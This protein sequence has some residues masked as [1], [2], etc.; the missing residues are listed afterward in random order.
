MLGGPALHGGDGFTKVMYRWS[1]VA[2]TAK[3]AARRRT[4]KMSARRQFSQSVS[5]QSANHLR[6]QRLLGQKYSKKTGAN[7]RPRI[8]SR[9]SARRP[10]RY[11]THDFAGCCLRNSTSKIIRMAP[12]V[13]AESAT[14]N[15]GQGLKMR[16]GRNLSQTCRKSVTAPWT[17]RS[18]TLPVAPARS[19]ASPAALSEFK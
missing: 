5:Y 14:L 1:S 16:Q 13:T 7:C 3:A 4:P 19:S 6:M 18:V 11:S 12:M 9:L 17:I 8:V 10:E 2:V 15:V